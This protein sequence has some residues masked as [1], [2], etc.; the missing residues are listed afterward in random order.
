MVGLNLLAE[1]LDH[2]GAEVVLGSEL[3]CK[4]IRV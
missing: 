2:L 3:V 1:L 4:R